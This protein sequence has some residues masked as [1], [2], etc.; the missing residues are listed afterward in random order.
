MLLIFFLL[1]SCGHHKYTQHQIDQESQRI[2]QFFEHV[3]NEDINRY[4]EY[5]TYIGSKQNY[6]KLNDISDEFVDNEIEITHSN[7]IKLRKF[8]YHSLND[9]AKI[10]Y[11]LFERNSLIEIDG[12]QYRYHNYPINQMFGRHSELISFMLNMHQID[13]I[14]EAEAYLSRL[15]QFESQLNQLINKLEKR[16]IKGIIAPK[17]VYPKVISDI[18]NIIQNNPLLS[19]FNQKINKL[20]I[21][22]QKKSDLKRKL[23]TISASKVVPSYKKLKNYLLKLESIAPN[24]GNASQLPDGKKF[25]Q[26]KLARTTTLNL[27]ADQVHQIGLDETKRIHQE[28]MIIKSKVNYRNSLNDFFNFMRTDQRFRYPDTIQG[29]KQYILDTEKI[30]ANIKNKLPEMF[31]ILPKA[32]LL[33]KQVEPYREKS[34]GL[35]FYQ[36]PAE[37]GSR[38]GIYYI[39]LSDMQAV[40]RYEQEALA[41]HEAIPGHHMQISIAKELTDIPSFRKHG[42]YTAYIEGWGLYAEYLPKLYGFYQ[43]PYSDFGRLSMELWRAARLVVDTGLHAKNWSTNQAI[44]WLDENTPST[45]DENVRAIQRYIVMPAQATAYKIGMNK[46]LELKHYAQNKLQDKFDIKSFHDQIL[47]NGSLPLDNLEDEIHRWVNSLIN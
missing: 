8:N 26:Y 30:I 6:D 45:H 25:Y 23:K 19:D 3:F 11:K 24:E 22:G 35:A 7:L 16:K 28:M 38:P 20:N 4:P 41:Y 34:A 29:R 1:I 9:Q 15:N 39:N 42:G 21:P 17:F 46:I 37:D 5:Q 32:D 12:H 27:S 10:S 14:T 47:K 36:G 40:A 44:K 18:D 31:G 43:D 13:N 2:N 33:I